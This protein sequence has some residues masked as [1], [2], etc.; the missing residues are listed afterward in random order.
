MKWAILFLV[1][2]S[3]LGAAFAQCNVFAVNHKYYGWV[4][5]HELM[6]SVANCQR[7][8]LN[9][10][11]SRRLNGNLGHG[12]NVL[13]GEVGLPM[14]D[15]PIDYHH[16]FNGFVLPP[17]TLV[18]FDKTE[19]SGFTSYAMPNFATARSLRLQSLSGGKNYPQYNRGFFGK[20]F[21]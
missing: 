18:S 4:P 11:F 16:G 8:E 17:A 21:F 14:V 20:F 10:G 6:H 2:F 9:G 3:T 7:N 1:L 19:R 15:I 5:R 12:F 13:N